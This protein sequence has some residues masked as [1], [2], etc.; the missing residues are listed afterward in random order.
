M[1][2]SRTKKN[3]VWSAWS[4]PTYWSMW[5]EDGMDGA[6]VEYIFRI[7]SEE[8]TSDMLFAE[9]KQHDI[10]NH[11]NYQKDNFYPGGN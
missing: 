4:L 9:F 7:T 6:G 8:F 11:P 1:V 10:Y 3:D 2:C 5:G